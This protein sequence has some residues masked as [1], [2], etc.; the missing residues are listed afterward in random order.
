MRWVVKY[1]VGWEVGSGYQTPPVFR[2]GQLHLLL[3]CMVPENSEETQVWG[4][5]VGKVVLDWM[6]R[7]LR[8]PGE[9]K[10][11]KV[12]RKLSCHIK[13][14]LWISIGSILLN[15]SLAAVN[16]GANQGTACPV[17]EHW[18]RRAWRE[19]ERMWEPSLGSGSHLLGAVGALCLVLRIWRQEDY[20]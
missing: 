1:F 6:C 10:Q 18:G 5:A 12:E 13:E 16:S 2:P 4:K 7:S 3:P 11:H 14:V 17:E 15:T 20:C 8:L 9:Q 19:M